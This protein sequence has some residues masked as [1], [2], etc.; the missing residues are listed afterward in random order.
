MAAPVRDEVQKRRARMEHA[1]E[2]VGLAA[3]G[4]GEEAVLRL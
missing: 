4:R 2:V 1:E 3:A